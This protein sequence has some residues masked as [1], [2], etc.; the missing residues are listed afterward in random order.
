VRSLDSCF[1]RRS[2]GH[3]RKVS[4]SHLNAEHLLRRVQLCHSHRGLKTRIRNDPLGDG[5]T[6][7]NGSTGACPMGSTVDTKAQQDG[8]GVE[9]VVV[10]IA[11]DHLVALGCGENNAMCFLYDI[12]DIESPVHLKTFNLSPSSR[13]RNPEQTYLDDLGDIDAETIQFIYPGQSP[14]GKSGFI[15]GGAIS[16]TL[17]FWEFECASEET[18]QSGSGGGQSQELSDSDESLEGGAIAGIV[19]GS[20]VGFA[21]LAVIALR[22]IGGNKKEIDTGKTG[23][24]DHTETVDGLA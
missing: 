4:L 13:N 12:S 7:N 24:S 15:F 16:G 20:V 11:C 5:C 2:G 1:R 22:A 17:S 10:G 8:L 18:A 23:S 14:T 6:F 3:Q 19:I 9:T 21:L